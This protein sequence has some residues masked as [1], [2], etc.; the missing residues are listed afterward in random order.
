MSTTTQSEDKNAYIAS[1]GFPVLVIIG[2]IIGYVF[3][4]P[5]QQISSWTTPLLGIIMFGMGL[6]M[7]ASDFVLVVKRP[8]PVLI[9]VIAQYVIM[10]AIA[11]FV[12][13]VMQLPPEI[14]AGVI[15]VGCAPGGTSSNVVSYLARG[16]VAL[17]VTMTSVSTLLAPI[18]TPLLTQWLAGQYMPLNGAAMAWS[19]V[20]VVLVPIA[21]GLLVSAL[22][23]K[24]VARFVPAMP[25]ISVVAISTIVAIVV[26]GSRDVILTAGLTVVIAVIVHNG[27]GYGLGWAT[28]KVTGQPQASRRTM[29]VEIGMQNSGLAASLA[30]QYMSPL[31]A[32]PAAVFSVWH[33]LSGAMLAALCRTIDKRNAVA[34]QVEPA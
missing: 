14:A 7:K 8:L 18:M 31:A 32:L 25:W 11:V 1:L 28:G 19:I 10:P 12:V 24:L 34:A 9:G 17:S 30:T 4:E 27:L 3:W 29:A 15:L 5:V 13:W 26:S 20:Q 16:D 21:A 2:G 33:N 6:T 23:P 22:L